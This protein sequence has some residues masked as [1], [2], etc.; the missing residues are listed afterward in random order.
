MKSLAGG[1]KTRQIMPFA[2]AA[3]GLLCIPGRAWAPTAVEYSVAGMW[4][5]F[6]L[7]SLTGESGPFTINNTEQRNRRFGG[8]LDVGTLMIPYEITLAASDR[9]PVVDRGTDG[10]FEEHHG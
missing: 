8:T 3:I 10:N 7:S 2:L 5:G 4:H 1:A 6:F 9:F